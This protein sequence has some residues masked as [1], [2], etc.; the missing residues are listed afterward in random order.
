MRTVIQSEI[1]CVPPVTA[2]RS[3]PLSRITGADFGDRPSLTEATPSITSPSDGMMS[4]ASTN[5]TSPDLETGARHPLVLGP[6]ALRRS[7]L[8]LGARAGAHRPAPL[9][10]LRHRLGEVRE[11]HRDPEPATM[12]WNGNRPPVARSRR[13]I[14]V[15]RAAT[16]STTNMTGFFIR[17]RGLSLAK[18]APIAGMTIF[19]SVRPIR[20]FNSGVNLSI[21]AGPDC[22][23]QRHVR[24]HGE[25]LDDRPERERG[26]EREAADDEDHADEQT[27]EQAPVVGKVPADSGT[28]F[29]DQRAGHRHHRDDHEISPD[30]HGDAAGRVVPERIAGE[31]AE[32]GTVVGGL[33]REQVEHCQLVRAR[34]L[35]AG[36]AG[37]ITDIEGEH[38]QRQDQNGEH[39]HFDL[40]RSSC[41][42]TCGATHHQAGHEHGDDDHEQHA[43][44]ARAD[45]A[46]DDLAKLAC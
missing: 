24:L 27:H 5:T 42:G 33:R 26:E 37:S 41:P 20:A 38:R 22:V 14:T 11:Q 17:T 23:R 28:V 15:V 44:E 40:L 35:D 21:A 31:A 2:E 39:R 45:A 25:M 4:P 8:R 7:R 46:E 32:G 9:A 12:I 6:V 18:A 34:I 10:A 43:V 3:P 16:T 30:Q 1:T 36:Q 19:G 13:K 29:D